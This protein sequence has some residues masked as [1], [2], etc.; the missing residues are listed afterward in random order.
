[1]NWSILIVDD[2]SAIRM[3]LRMMLQMD[4]FIVH[5]ASNGKKALMKIQE[6][7]PD[8]VLLDVMMPQM[9]G[10]TLA[11]IIRSQPETAALPIIMFSGKVNP[12][13]VQEGLDAGA[14]RY[15]PKP[16]PHEYLRAEIFAVMEETRNKIIDN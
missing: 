10:I 11:K 1:M 15:L 16:T 6:S 7:I 5:E 9:D 8:L 2:D 3:M 12:K 4:G 14:N 13:A